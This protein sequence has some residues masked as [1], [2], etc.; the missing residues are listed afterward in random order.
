MSKPYPK[1]T[2]NKS[3]WSTCARCCKR[4]EG[5]CLAAIEG[6]FNC[7]ESVQKIKK[8]PKSRATRREGKQVTTIGPDYS[9]QKKNMF[10]VLQVKND[11]E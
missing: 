1:E 9:S 11:K 3:L 7:G 4:H 5:R 8:N 6:F 2:V 10:Y